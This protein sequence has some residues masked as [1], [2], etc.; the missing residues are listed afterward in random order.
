[1]APFDAS[2]S[3][4]LLQQRLIDTNTLE[5][6]TKVALQ[7]AQDRLEL[8]AS[9]LVRALA[10]ERTGCFCGED[11]SVMDEEEEESIGLEGREMSQRSPI[12]D[13]D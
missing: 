10:T 3:G 12:E 8:T 1:M 11:G 6:S 2:A 7:S 4:L 9:S 13:R 5:E